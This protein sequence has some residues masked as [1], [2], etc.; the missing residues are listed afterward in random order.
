MKTGEMFPIKRESGY[1]EIFDALITRITGI[2]HFKHHTGCSFVN[3]IFEIHPYYFGQCL[4]N[5]RQKY[6]EYI[7][8]NP[9]KND[10]FMVE[11][12]VLNDAFKNHPQYY[13]NNK[14]KAERANEERK[15]C[16][17][18][19]VNYKDGKNLSEVCNCGIHV[20][21]SSFNH[22]HETG[23]PVILPNFWFKSEENP[24]KIFWY[25]TYFRDSTCTKN[26]TLEEFR[27]IV[28]VCL[29]SV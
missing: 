5:Y 16:M 24:I 8:T 19:K 22:Q 28:G 23:C 4:C 14:L 12:N 2:E 29:N 1:E 17:A 18:H 13:S 11:L 21:F 27:N 7:Q 15:L 10:C 20:Q 26:L 6:Q 9:H 3:N 25:K